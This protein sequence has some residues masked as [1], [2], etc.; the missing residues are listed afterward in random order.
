M[1]PSTTS[2]THSPPRSADRSGAT[3][4]AALDP[5]FVALLNGDGVT[6]LVTG[7]PGDDTGE[8]NSGAVLVLFLESD[9]T[10]KD[11]RKISLSSDFYT[12]AGGKAAFGR[13]VAGLGDL[14]G[15]G[16]GD[17]LVGAPNEYYPVYKT[18]SVWVL[19]LN[20]DGGLKSY[21]RIGSG[22]PQGGFVGPIQRYDVF[23]SGV[24]FL[25]VAVL[26]DRA[27]LH[28]TN[29]IGHGQ[30]I[31]GFRGCVDD[32]CSFFSKEILQFRS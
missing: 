15:D 24:D 22:F 9:G 4:A 10:L 21:R 17:L 29:A 25:G 32:D 18:G 11:Y 28:V 5:N 13:S 7:L 3:W 14:D 26:D 30:G 16:V 19:F 2:S 8:E 1:N 20:A 6:D 31:D 12:S 23:G 27:F